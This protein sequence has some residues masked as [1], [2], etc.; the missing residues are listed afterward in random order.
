MKIYVNTH[1]VS[2]CVRAKAHFWEYQFLDI[3][4]RDEHVFVSR[5]YID[6]T[7]QYRK[8]EDMEFEGFS[9]DEPVK[10][11]VISLFNKLC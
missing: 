6:G 10:A 9:L 4:N 11:G 1:R 8:S 2:L 7:N 5:F 3:K